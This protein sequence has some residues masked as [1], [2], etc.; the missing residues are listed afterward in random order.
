MSQEF[1]ATVEEM[2]ENELAAQEL[3][4]VNAEANTSGDVVEEA[5]EGV[6]KPK[7]D[8][9][10]RSIF[11]VEDENGVEH[12]FRSKVDVD[13]FL[14]KPRVKKALLEIA[15]VDEAIVAFILDNEVAI[16]AAFAIASP[17]QKKRVISE[18]TREKMR[19]AMKARIA[20]GAITPIAK[21][22]DE[23]VETVDT[24]VEA[25]SGEAAQ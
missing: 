14:A 11:V 3:A 19:E 2:V 13:K 16:K 24:V 22:A 25:E 4:E 8:F 21:K 5:A 20:S 12:E 1:D 6:T 10:Q 23:S 17:E 7:R 15:G 9:K 18:E